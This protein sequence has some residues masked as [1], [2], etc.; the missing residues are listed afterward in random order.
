MAP[1]VG[2][3]GDAIFRRI[4]VTLPMENYTHR[5]VRASVQTDGTITFSGS[6]HT[7]GEDAQACAV[8]SK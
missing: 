4:P 3:D 5:V 6:A 7:R 1:T 8:N 2:A